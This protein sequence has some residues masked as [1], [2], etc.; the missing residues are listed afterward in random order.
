MKNEIIIKQPMQFV[1]SG[2]HLSQRKQNTK[3]MVKY[4]RSIAL[5]LLT[6]CYSE[7]FEEAQLLILKHQMEEG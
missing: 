2:F 4:D 7:E 1:I 6:C 5:H 3:E